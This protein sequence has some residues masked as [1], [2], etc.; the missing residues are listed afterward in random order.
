MASSA[1]KVTPAKL[2]AS[3]RSGLSR[4]QDQL[5]A[6]QRRLARAALVDLDRG[7]RRV[8]PGSWGDAS[9]RA[10]M[11]LL[12]QALRT[13][14]DR[15]IADLG[16]GLSEVTKLGARDAAKLLTTLDQHYLGSVRPLR[17]DTAAW[18]ER[19]DKRIGQV[20]LRKFSKSFRRYGAAAVASIEDE[21]GKRI[22]TGESWAKARSAVWEATR[23]VVGDRRWM[24]DRII[25]TETAA[26]YN[27]TTLAA[28][29]EEDTDAEDPMM[30]RLVATFDK[31]TGDDSV[32]V[33]GQTKRLSE[34][35]VD[36]KGREYDAPPNRPH[37]REIVVGWRSSYGDDI[38]DFVGDTAAARDGDPDAPRMVAGP[39]LEPK[40]PVQPPPTPMQPAAR[41]QQLER[42][43]A[44]IKANKAITG[45]E[46]STILQSR[47]PMKMLQNATA[48]AIAQAQAHNASVMARVDALRSELRDMQVA[49][50]R[51]EQQIRKAKKAE[52]QKKAVGAPVE[53]VPKPKAIPKLEGAGKV[54]PKPKPK[55][56]ASERD[57]NE[58]KPGHWLDLGGTPLRVDAVN[59]R[60]EWATYVLD[61]G[62]GVRYRL[63]VP[64]RLRWASWDAKPRLAD[65]EGVD[66]V[67]AMSKAGRGIRERTAAAFKDLAEDRA[68]LQA[69]MQN[70]TTIN[71]RYED[72]LA[73]LMEKL[74]P[75]ELERRA[76]Q[77]K[78]NAP[79][80]KLDG[81]GS[82]AAQLKRYVEGKGIA[83]KAK[84]SGFKQARLAREYVHE[85]D[86]MRDRLRFAGI[87]LEKL[88]ATSRKR[89]RAAAWVQWRENALSGGAHAPPSGVEFHINIA[90]MG[91]EAM[92]AARRKMQRAKG[93]VPWT[94][95]LHL[96]DDTTALRQ[97]VRHE[98]GHVVDVTLRKAARTNEDDSAFAGAL[99]KLWTRRA[100]ALKRSD[101]DQLSEYAGTDPRS[102][103]LA[104][105]FAAGYT[106]LWEHVP[107]SLR[108]PIRLMLTKK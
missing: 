86:Y 30:K 7:L 70:L 50:A 13:L 83:N 107:E 14:N 54:K 36:D 27:G 44:M 62:Q 68:L 105:A 56:K 40:A 55:P 102:E 79:A 16:L 9:K 92:I 38:P 29:H 4:A 71:S 101:W 96:S 32:F 61:L 39:K 43:L 69:H 52:Q 6:R 75:K 67:L 90:A 1:L 46:I 74:E 21:L 104:E 25:R 51:V 73:E 26:A 97:T 23:D 49:Q 72:A 18:W 98:M 2:L 28:L 77:L 35:F 93:G 57:G 82:L 81:K 37:D 65:L 8:A 63:E 20:R 33:H 64:S 87:E 59:V 22:L 17:F 58:L 15:Q 11:V 85:V 89:G 100:K 103:G 47:I 88:A 12:G 80:V 99:L 5:A 78:G 66:H 60:G 34:K 53:R 31:V 19:T 42:Q 24:V 10:A 84:L 91:D 95:G 106:G 48:E 94:H 45:G 76:L 3:Q 41:Q 108:L